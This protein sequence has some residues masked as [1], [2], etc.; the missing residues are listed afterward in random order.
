MSYYPEPGSHI[1]DKVKVVLGLS[2]YI[3]KKELDHATGV[4]TSGLAAKKGFIA[5]KGVFDKRDINKLV[6]VPTS[7]NNFKT[8]VDDLDVG[9]LKTVPV[10]LLKLS[11]VIA[12]KVVNSTKYNTLKTKVNNLEK[13]IL[14]ATIIIQ[15]N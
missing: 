14:D 13:I 5:L 15:I 9:K 8:K 7:L 2:N 12:D 11:D 6:N 1:R 10:D 4:D 3:T